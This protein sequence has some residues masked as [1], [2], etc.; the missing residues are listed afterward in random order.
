MSLVNSDILKFVLKHKNDLT[1]LGLPHRFELFHA[2]E[3]GASRL[4]VFRME[5]YETSES[6]DLAQEIWDCAE[7]DAKTRTVGMNQRYALLMFRQEEDREHE[8]QLAFN[9]RG[10]SNSEYSFAGNSDKASPQGLQAQQMRHNE[11]L[12]SMM[13]QQTEVT[14]GRLVRE[15]DRM[16]ARCEHLE[17][18]FSEMLNIREALEDKSHERKLEMQR[19]MVK[20]SRQEQVSNLFM[21]M[22]PLLA[23]KFLGGGGAIAGN[24]PA[25]ASRDTAIGSLLGSLSADEM[26]KI[27]GALTPE[28]QQSLMQIYASYK[29]DFD[30]KE[31][32]QHGPQEEIYHS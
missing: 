6:E 11:H 23:A 24:L 8:A 10:M 14:H 3:D 7:A 15:C 19:E 2:S 12:I 32:K 16:R 26:G 1:S 31:Q 17:N 21:T 18:K 27:L 13:T 29:E 9:I 25:Q 28:N 22:A 20:A 5:V 30:Q 4:N